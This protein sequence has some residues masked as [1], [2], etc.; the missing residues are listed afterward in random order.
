MSLEELEAA[1]VLL[2]PE[3]WRKRKLK[4]RVARL[5]LLGM[6]ALLPVSIG[7]IY[8]GDGGGPTWVGLAIF[9]AILA[10]FIRVS[11]RGIK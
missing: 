8:F 7:L 6:G 4:S 9:F 11:L 10:G 2:P 5:P 1:G 3:K